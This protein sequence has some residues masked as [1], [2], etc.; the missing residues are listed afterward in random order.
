MHFLGTYHVLREKINV[1]IKC[2]AQRLFIKCMPALFLSVHWSFIISN[3]CQTREN[4]KREMLA[5][6][7]F[8][9]FYTF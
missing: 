9:L 4:E 7:N 1:H 3:K 5:A 6:F 8:S 2:N